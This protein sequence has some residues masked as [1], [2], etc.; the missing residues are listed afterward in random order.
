MGTVASEPSGNPAGPLTTGSVHQAELRASRGSATAGGGPQRFN[1]RFRRLW[2]TF[3][4]ASLGDGF[5]AGAVPLLAVVVDPRPFAV[6]AVVAANSVPW[7]L[8]ALHAGA[9]ADRFERARVMAVSN[10]ARALVLVAMTVVVATHHASY[11][12]LVLFVLANAAARAV[13]YSASQAAMTELVDATR[14]NRANGVLYGTEAAT[15]DLAGPAL[16]T[17][18]FA[19]AQSIPFLV[20]AIAM[21]TSGLSLLRLRTARPDRVARSHQLS[22]G[23]RYVIAN[24]EIRLLVYLIASLAGLQGLVSGVLVLI[25]TR[26]WHVSTSG[27]GAFLAT[28]AVGLMVGAFLADRVARRMGSVAALISCAGV[29][30]LAYLVM[31]AARYWV[32]AGGAFVFVGLAIGVG[33]PIAISLRQRLTPPELMGRVG[34]AWR[35]IVWGAAPTGALVAGGLAVVGGLRLPVFLAGGA[36]CVVALLL[37]RPMVKRL[38][39]A[40]SATPE[41]A[42]RRPKP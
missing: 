9:I 17:V 35:G 26:D 12:L 13:Y 2:V 22:E 37:V 21:L 25:A 23:I 10:L 16:G 11:L 7:L 18:A 14:F 39:R 5:I 32:L 42:T 15:E 24:R 28:Q 38:G 40:E 41:E 3:G 36:Q 19:A 4:V 6:S 34:S 20:D 8:M 27:Y 1:R 29:S 31:G 33:N 30:G